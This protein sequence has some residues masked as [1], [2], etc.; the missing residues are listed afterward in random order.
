EPQQAAT[1]DVDANGHFRFDFLEADP[2]NSYEVGVQYQGAPYVSD[3]LTFGAGETLRAVS[4]DVYE[5]TD[6]DSVLS[7]AATSLLVDPDEKTREL[8]V[9][10]LDSFMNAA[11]RTFVPNTTPRNGG[12]PPLLRFSLP[13]NATDL[14][15]SSGLTPD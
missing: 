3:K 5:P 13:A 1:A 11:Q 9:L 12:P 2:A 15:P 14:T 8:V 4:L 10:E 7:L 6:D